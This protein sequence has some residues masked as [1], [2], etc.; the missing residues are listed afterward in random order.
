MKIAI[1]GAGYA[2]LA[3][4]FELSKIRGNQ[5]E[6]IERADRAGGMAAGFKAKNWRWA[7]EDHYHHVFDSDLDFARFVEELGLGDQLFYQKSKSGTL[8]HGKIHRLDSPATLLMFREI[9]FVSRLRTGVVLAFLKLVGNGVF[10]ERYTA[11]SFLRR[12]MGEESWQVIWQP[13]FKSKFGSKAEEINMAWFWARVKPR[14]QFLGYVQGGFQHLADKAKD[15]L[16]Q[17]GVTFIFNRQVSKITKKGDSY[18]LFLNK[19]SK[20]LVSKEVEK[21]NYDLVITTLSSPLMQQ[22]LPELPEFRARKLEGLAA[23]TLLLRLKDKLLTDGTYWLN[24]N[25]S[26][27]PFVAVVEHDNFID[28]KYYGNESLV[29]LGRYLPVT[30]KNYQ[31]TS[32]ELLADYLPYLRQINPQ[33][34]QILISAEV[35]KNAFAQPISYLNYGRFLPKFETRWPGLYWISLQHVYPFDRGV[36]HA[37]RIGRDLAIKLMATGVVKSA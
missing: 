23:M 12:Y 25:E 14:S 11:A 32:K 31:K 33:I 2:G 4:A 18:T 5:V 22:L 17:K 26:N 3:A 24:V 6:L 37:I 1:I 13:L 15:K 8:Y 34:D 19:I 20:N 10:L 27:W 16:S 30:D 36:N 28:S 21:R 29:Y 7:L 9:S 35:K